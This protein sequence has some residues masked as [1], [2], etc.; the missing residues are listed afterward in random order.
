MRAAL[1]AGYCVSTALYIWLLGILAFGISESG[2][3]AL[4][5]EAPHLQIQ[6]APC[7]PED[8]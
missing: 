8:A 4:D 3:D 7:Q 5:A 2:G 6:A 1:D